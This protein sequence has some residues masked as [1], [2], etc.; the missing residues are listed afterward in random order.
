[1]FLPELYHSGKQAITMMSSISCIQTLIN[2]SDI[3]VINGMI[4]SDWINEHDDLN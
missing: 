4:F 2:S 1:M 3:K